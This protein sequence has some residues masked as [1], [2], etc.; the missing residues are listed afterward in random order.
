MPMLRGLI[1]CCV[2][3]G[4]LRRRLSP[5]GKSGTAKLISSCHEHIPSYMREAHEVAPLDFLVRVSGEHRAVARSCPRHGAARSGWISPCPVGADIIS[6][7]T[8][9]MYWLIPTLPYSTGKKTKQQMIKLFSPNSSQVYA[10]VYF[11]ACIRQQALL[12]FAD[13]WP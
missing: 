13:P 6:S 9:H 4:A 5:G 7:A 11:V 1:Q 3:C 12:V 8:L 10:W 2:G